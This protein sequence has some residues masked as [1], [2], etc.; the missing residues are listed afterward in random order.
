MFGSIGVYNKDV[1]GIIDDFKKL[2]K[3]H[4]RA[5]GVQIKHIIISFEKQPDL[6]PRK[7]RKLITKTLKYF[8]NE[9]QLVYAV[10]EDTDNLHVHIGI[11]SVSFE[12]KKFNFKAKDRHKFEKRTKRIFADYI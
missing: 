5:G 8:G 7:L 2:K 10:H 3:I 12:G 4:D 9:Y 1:L 6:T 11:N